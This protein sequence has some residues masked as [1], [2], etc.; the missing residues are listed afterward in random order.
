VL[1]AIYAAG[2]A[3]MESLR[4]RP[5]WETSPRTPVQFQRYVQWMLFVSGLAASIV[6]LKYLQQANQLGDSQSAVPL[7]TYDEVKALRKGQP[8]LLGSLLFPAIAIGAINFISWMI[9]FFVSPDP[10]KTELS[11]RSTVRT[12]SLVAFANVVSFTI[13]G[14]IAGIYLGLL[15][16]GVA[17]FR[18]F[19]VI[20][21]ILL[22]LGPPAVVGAVFLAETIHVGLTSTTR[23][24]DAEREWLATAAGRHGRM[25]VV[26][27]LVT[28]VVFGGAYVIFYVNH[29][30][31]PSWFTRLFTLST[32]GGFA[33]LVVAWLGKASATAATLRERYDTWKNWS[34]NI[35]LSIATPVFLVITLTLLSAGIDYLTAGGGA[36]ISSCWAIH[37]YRT[38][39][40]AL[41]DQ[42]D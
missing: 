14:V 18:H 15:F 21:F 7:P 17:Q 31:G 28:L 10:N 1:A 24:S 6:A 25:A 8:T 40:R 2:I 32:T 42:A 27:M 23:W 30:D 36:V 41:S 34:A 33:A 35:I 26:W 19:E 5:G 9:A 20:A 39:A 4:Q 22:C 38:L 37:R 12:D 29:D 11:T 13:S 3:T 16:Y